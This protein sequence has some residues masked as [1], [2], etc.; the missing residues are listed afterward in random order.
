MDDKSVKYKGVRNFIHGVLL[1]ILLFFVLCSIALD[2]FSFSVSN[3]Y[4]FGEVCNTIWLSIMNMSLSQYFTFIGA[5]AFVLFGVAGIYDF[6]YSQG[7]QWLVPPLFQKIK[8]TNLQKQAEIMMTQYYKR[9]IENIK[10]YE[11]E[12]TD[13]V[14]HSLGLK[15]SQFTHIRYEIIKAR[16]MK[17]HSIDELKEKAKSFIENNHELI[18]DLSKIP[19]ENRA[20]KNVDYYLD[21]Y[22][23]FYD[24]KICGDF[25]EI[26]YSFIVTNLDDPNI[27]YILVPEDSNIL[28]GLEVAKKF[29]KPVIAI[30]QSGR[31]DSTI[32]F[33]GDFFT[34][35][36]GGLPKR[37][38]IL[39][40]VLV[41]GGRIVDCINKI[42]NYVEKIDTI[43]SNSYKFEGLFCIALYEG[44]ISNKKPY[45]I[46]KPLEY[47]KENN[48]TE[49]QCHYLITVSKEILKDVYEKRVEAS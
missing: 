20:Y 23:G 39:H 28:L 13:Y 4:S 11:L 45:E 48:I 17:T 30:R 35:E 44:A 49:E 10:Q 14:L 9:E 2:S 8:D 3:Q 29:Q 16:A 47:L 5:I 19:E 43:P 40:D 41:S 22:S 33:D 12:R 15:E 46:L 27:D 18:K 26:M 31:L 6:A 34:S 25:A 37:F 42:N 24:S 1:I 32:P 36:K 7:I 38:I 21:F